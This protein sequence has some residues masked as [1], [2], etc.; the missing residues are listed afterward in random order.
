[1][2]R[3]TDLTTAIQ[4]TILAFLARCAAQGA[5]ALPAIGLRA[6]QLTR[7]LELDADTLSHLI[8]DNRPVVQVLIQPDALDAALARHVAQQDDCAVVAQLILRGASASMMMAVGGISYND[9]MARRKALGASCKNGRPK[10]PDD[11]TQFKIY[12]VWKLLGH[13]DLRRRYIDLHDRFPELP[14]GVLWAVN[15][16]NP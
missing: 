2:I 7:L 15:Q 12:K 11:D 13:P 1:M 8:L 4:A 5:Q 10:L 9:L 16:L 3:D 6:N 14:I